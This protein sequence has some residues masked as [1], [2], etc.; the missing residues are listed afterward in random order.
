MGSEGEGRDRQEGTQQASAGAGR[1]GNVKRGKDRGREKQKHPVNSLRQEH[2]GQAPGVCAEVGTKATPLASQLKCP[3]K[4]HGTDKQ[5]FS[6]DLS[7][8]A[9]GVLG[10]ELYRRLGGTQIPGH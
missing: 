3:P 9:A 1:Q 2:R 5:P 6:S 10:T 7:H 4:T 8:Q